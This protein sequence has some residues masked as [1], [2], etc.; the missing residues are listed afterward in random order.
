MKPKRHIILLLVTALTFETVYGNTSGPND[1]D[2]D[3][4]SFV[5]G[6]RPME[7]TT[8]SLG[9]Y[10]EYNM[11]LSNGQPDIAITLYE[12]KS[13]DLTVPIVLRYQSGG[14][15]VKQDATWV[16][17]G[18]DL[19]YGGQV[20][21]TV[22]GLP[23]EMEQPIGERPTAAEIYGL[24]PIY[25]ATINDPCA[26]ENRYF[27][28]MAFDIYK[29]TMPDE[30][31][32]TIGMESGKF[33]GKDVEAL[34]PYKP[35]Q[36]FGPEGIINAKG[37]IF[38]FTAKETTTTIHAFSYTSAWNLIK[39]QSPNNNEITYTYQ[40]D[41]KYYPISYRDGVYEEYTEEWCDNGD[42]YC[43]KFTKT[44]LKNASVRPNITSYKPEYITFNGG[45]LKFELSPRED[46]KNTAGHTPIKKLESI[47]VQRLKS[48]NTYET[49][50]EIKFEYFYQN[51]S[52]KERLM[53]S[54]V[55]EKTPDNQTQI[56]AKFEY[57]ATVLPPKTSYSYDFCGYYN[58][59]GSNITP[60]P[61][62]YIPINHPSGPIILGGS[63]KTVSETKSKAGVLTAVEYPT[64]GKTVFTWENHRYGANEPLVKEHYVQQKSVNLH[65][66]DECSF[67][68]N[69]NP[70]PFPCTGSLSHGINCEISQAVNVNGYIK[71]KN[72]STFHK[73]DIA[74][75]KVGNKVVAVMNYNTLE[76]E[77]NV[78]ENVEI[79]G[80]T[81]FSIE[82]NCTENIEV[83][84]FF[85]YKDI[86]YNSQINNFI[87]GGLRIK[88]ITNYDTDGTFLEKTLYT[89]TQPNNP[90][91]SSGYITNIYPVLSHKRIIRAQT[92]QTNIPPAFCDCYN[93]M[94][95][96][97]LYYDN[98]I[99]LYPNNLSYQFVQ[100][101]KVNANNETTG[102]IKY[103]YKKT[104]D[105]RIDYD[106]PVISN[107]S[108]RGQLLKKSIFGIFDN[109]YKI[110]KETENTYSYYPAALGI[111]WGF[112][113]IPAYRMN[114]SFCRLKNGFT[115]SD[116]F[117]PV[118]YYNVSRWLKLDST[119]D[120][121]YFGDYIVENITNY[122]YNDLNS[123]LPTN[124]V[125]FYDG[126]EKMVNYEYFNQRPV[127]K[128]EKINNQPAVKLSI[129]Y[130]T[131][132]L[133]IL[134]PPAF[135]I[136]SVNVKYKNE[137]TVT[138]IIVNLHDSNNN[139]LEY[140]T[141]DNVP[142]ALVW[143]YKRKYLIA[144]IINA[145]Y[146]DVLAK[147]TDIETISGKIEPI[148]SDFTKINNLRTQLPDA[149]VTTFKYRTLFGL[150]EIT[151]PHNITTYFIY[152]AFGRL[153]EI[154]I[155]EKTYPANGETLK[156]VE[157]YMYHFMQ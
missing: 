37:E 94:T 93:K 82:N 98:P 114:L 153:I 56:I 53:L 52:D 150:S 61:Y 60:V 41:G 133:C 31:Y 142:V 100:E 144:E 24:L 116:L 20:T 47:L 103:E 12:V 18:W 2:D 137:A 88:E 132:P 13:G 104:L 85:T 138:E 90:N 97:Y 58:D 123:C 62:H 63:D 143:G 91:K 140:E 27:F 23:D 145:T 155:G 87:Y 146:A 99:G 86:N 54:R 131:E 57:D 107:A 39:I 11:D 42:N 156:K 81:T 70:P 30:Y 36:I 80:P 28:D 141:K 38:T 21:R 84:V 25:D 44:G 109:E 43:I 73:Q 152:D 121:D 69:Q 83:N 49:V 117:F 110:L 136:N 50:K 95:C 96:H 79:I 67:F 89:Y 76:N 139:I 45:R 115:Y 40:Y 19:F 111:T 14:I 29:S 147:I 106:L 68:H 10:G 48:N 59:N 92:I 74:K 9:R 8:A 127:I 46:I 16:G 65:L 55:Y 77:I 72:N 34:I 119:I 33:I 108:E 64:S 113:L 102:I 125:T 35:F 134:C 105:E 129:N 71:R 22:Y 7:P 4:T 17:L 151:D 130:S 101:Q 126:N 120:R 128:E 154:K 1:P 122:T 15:K 51:S 32:Y 149:M 157:E 124:I 6:I 78:N 26:F 148:S 135:K 66:D 118:D 5:N 75:I 3:F 112:K